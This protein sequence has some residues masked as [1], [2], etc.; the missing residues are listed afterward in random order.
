ME[1]RPAADDDIVVFDMLG[2]I[3][4]PWPF[5]PEK[6][7]GI[8]L[9][10]G[11]NAP[12]PGF[13]AQLVGLSAR[14]R[15]TLSVAVP[16]GADRADLVGQLRK[17]EIE[18]KEVRVRTPAPIDD[19]LAQKGGW[20]SLV[21]FKAWL[22]KQHD[23]ELKSLSRL[24]LKRLL[25]DR[26]A[27]LYN[28]AVP[29]GLVQREYELLVRQHQSDVA[30]RTPLEEEH[31]HDE[32]CEHDHDHS[33]EHVD[34][35]AQDIDAALSKEERTDYQGLA[36]RR[37]RLGLLLAEIGRTNNLRVQQDELAKAM[38]AHARRFSGQE[39]AVLEF[40]RRNPEAQE[41]LAAPILEEKVV[42]FI[43]E[44]A[45]VS[46]RVVDPADLLREQDDETTFASD[47]KA[48]HI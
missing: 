27:E 9:R 29:K 34:Q 43:L 40:L 32:H 42:D 12:L 6:L 1:D 47:T 20:K 37:V 3:D 16:E 10:I 13:D 18:V 28:F 5:D 26:L 2:P 14:T 15:T 24:R 44:M 46:E 21:E 4:D 38:I 17:F 11:S 25:L 8:R 45:K 35:H 7:Q 41:A 23:D 39:E 19:E 31:V 33:Q 30:T 22:C 48:A 36:L